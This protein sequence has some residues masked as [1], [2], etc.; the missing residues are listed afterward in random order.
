[1]EGQFKRR[2]YSIWTAQWNFLWTDLLET[3]TNGFLAATFPQS[4]LHSAVYQRFNYV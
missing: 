4:T 2:S 3:G 1:M